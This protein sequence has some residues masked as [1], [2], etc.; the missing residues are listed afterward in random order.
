MTRAFTE[1][2]ELCRSIARSRAAGCPYLRWLFAR[3]LTMESVLRSWSEGDP[4]LERECAQILR[5]NGHAPSSRELDEL[6]AYCRGESSR[7]P[8]RHFEPS[9]L[10]VDD[11]R[12]LL[13][14]LARTLSQRRLRVLQA[15][16]P[17]QAL[18]VLTTRH[19]DIVVSDF[20]MPGEPNGL[21]L[22]A[23]VQRKFPLVRRVLMSG[24]RLDLDEALPRQLVEQF[25]PKT[26]A[27]RGIAADIER[28]A[29]ARFEGTS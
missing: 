7:K 20:E 23:E 12:L 26:R 8:S 6:L 1:G 9:V 2:I 4:E 14:S 22:L 13:R 3:F 5:N 25:I 19:V 21:E 10:L 16:T 28:L 11:D 18:L 24:M 15:T 29:R 17:A 27:A